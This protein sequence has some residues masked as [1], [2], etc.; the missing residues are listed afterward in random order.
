MRNFIEVSSFHSGTKVLIGVYGIVSVRASQ[1]AL[2][3]G[4]YIKTSDELLE[5]Q[6]NF[7]KVK[8]LMEEA[9]APLTMSASSTQMSYF[10]KKAELSET[11]P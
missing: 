3:N 4:T 10:G 2:R 1:Y 7:E 5:V 6:E 9:T 11:V 8:E